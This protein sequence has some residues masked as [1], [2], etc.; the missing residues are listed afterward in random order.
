MF[1]WSSFLVFFLLVASPS[2][3]KV[4]GLEIYAGEVFLE[5][6][7]PLDQGINRLPLKALVQVSSLQ[8]E[9]KGTEIL[10][11]AVERAKPQGPLA[12]RLE[13]LKGELQALLRQEKGLEEKLSLLKKVLEN[14]DEIPNPSVLKQYFALQDELLA[15]LTRLQERRQKLEKEIQ[16]L[17]KLVPQGEVSVLL[18]KVRQEGQLWVRY[19]ARDILSVRQAYRLELLSEKKEIILAGEAF[20]RQRAGEDWTGVKLKFYPRARPWA[21]IAPPPF[22]PWVIDLPPRPLA[23]IKGKLEKLATSLP[24]PRREKSPGLIWERVVVEG[25]NLPCGQE[26]LVPLLQKTFVPQKILLEVPLYAVN[27][28]Y[29]RAD[30]VPKISLPQTQAAFYLDGTYVGRGSLG[31]WVPG[32]EVRLYFGRAPLLE[33]K[34]ETL[35]DTSG[36]PFFSRGREIIEK[37]FRT[38]LINHYQR[39]FALE[40]V[41]RLPITHKKDIK[42]K[43]SANPPWEEVDSQGRVVWRFDLAPEEKAVIFLKIRIDRPAEK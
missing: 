2:Q 5:E 13:K 37:E 11:L 29:F 33:V 10:S 21:P 14:K 3:A 41:D 31:P 34:R 16:K 30:F 8:A 35:K 40:V 39:P 43:A 24:R 42:I 17:E 26:V 15:D 36:H 20:I 12:Q 19:P 22:K 9:P 1:R 6:V 28:G 38:T 25:V 32:K 27:Q 18:V 4:V 7:F 23:L